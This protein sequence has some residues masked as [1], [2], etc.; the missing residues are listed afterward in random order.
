M[1]TFRDVVKWKTQYQKRQWEA[2]AYEGREFTAAL[3]EKDGRIA[4]I[5]LNRPEVK[6][7]LND[8]A[9]EDMLAGF[10]KANDDPEVRVVVIKGAGTNFCAGHDLSSPVGEESPPVHPSLAPTVRDYY[11]IERRRCSKYEDLL[12]FPKATIAQVHGHCIGAGVEI[13]AACDITIA[14]EDAQFGL[15]G[16]GAFPLGVFGG[17]I[18]SWPSASQRLSAGKMLPEL[19]GKD[20]ETIGAI[21]KAVPLQNLEQETR[22]WAQA[23]ADLSPDALALAKEFISGVLDIAGYGAAWRSHYE[24]HIG[25]QWVRFRPD[26]VSFYRSKKHGGLKGYLEERADHATPKR[27]KD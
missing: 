22:R 13:Q 16:F 14:A 27:K 1:T 10:H 9:F 11:N 12:R 26:E 19:S 4:I 5:T 3:Y 7:A 6:N 18:N 2:I 8:K 23:L 20:M 17:V 25:I 15:R 24:T 21:N